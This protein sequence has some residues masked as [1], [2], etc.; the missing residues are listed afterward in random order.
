MKKSLI[1]IC[2]KPLAQIVSSVLIVFAAFFT[3][4]ALMAQ[5]LPAKGCKDW[6]SDKDKAKVEAAFDKVLN[7]SATDSKLRAE[8]LDVSDCYKKPKAVVQRTL[9]GMPGDKVTI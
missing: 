6:P 8:L 9:D 2:T 7:D 5:H 3:V 4:S 1:N